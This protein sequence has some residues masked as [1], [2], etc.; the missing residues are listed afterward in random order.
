MNDINGLIESEL[1]PAL[2]QMSKEDLINTVVKLTYVCGGYKSAY[3]KLI[4]KN[5]AQEDNHL[6]VKWRQKRTR[7]KM[8]GT[9]RCKI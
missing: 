2:E 1:K 5:T 6:Y 9:E 8:R 4:K 3:E 7:D